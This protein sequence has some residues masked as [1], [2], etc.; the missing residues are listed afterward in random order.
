MPRVP[1][2]S[3]FFLFLALELSVDATIA[4]ARSTAG[5]ILYER[6]VGF[7]RPRNLEIIFDDVFVEM[8]H[9]LRQYIQLGRD[10][11]AT[12]DSS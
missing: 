6:D 2:D 9:D 3:P 11:T 12:E 4:G 8:A 5:R 10:E 7:E 1:G